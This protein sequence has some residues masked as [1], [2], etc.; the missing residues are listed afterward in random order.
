M[1]GR[2]RQ[3]STHA[4]GVL[5]SRLEHVRH[6]CVVKEYPVL[7]SCVVQ[8]RLVARNVGVGVSRCVEA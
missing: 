2:V 7:G 4:R 8:N 3:F 5:V 1:V 6:V